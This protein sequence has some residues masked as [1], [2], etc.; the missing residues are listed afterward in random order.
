LEFQCISKISFYFFF[1]PS[2]L[3]FFFIINY[4][5]PFYNLRKSLII[6]SSNFFF[7]FSFLIYRL[8]FYFFLPYLSSFFIINYVRPFYNMRKSLIILSS[9]FFLFICYFFKYFPN[10]IIFKLFYWT[11]VQKYSIKRKYISSWVQGRIYTFMG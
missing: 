4:V 5:R 8:F 1:L 7:I 10:Y 3:S 11:R 9:N 6:L 2:L